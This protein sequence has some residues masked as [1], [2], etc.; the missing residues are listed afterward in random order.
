MKPDLISKIRQELSQPVASERQVVYLL[1]ESRKLLEVEG[2]LDQYPSLRL[3]MDW[4]L[5]PVLER[6]NAKAILT[7]FNA[8]ETEYRKSGITMHEFGLGELNNFLSLQSFRK[9]FVEAL[10]LFDVTADSLTSD[11]HW[12]GFVQN[13]C[14]V[15]RDCP[16]KA[17]D[18]GTRI[19]LEVTA[20]AWPLEMANGIFPGKR[21]VQWN[22]KPRD[23]DRQ[24]DIC[25]LV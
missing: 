14:E 13:Y 3:C 9:E 1:V 11:E 16:L 21:V 6:K 19:V 8:Y 5:H 20:L 4:A 15:I 10:A 17:T 12:R 23:R 18:D 2:V 7:H 24:K 25:A 22:W